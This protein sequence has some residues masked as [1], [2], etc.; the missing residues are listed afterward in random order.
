MM[1]IEVKYYAWLR[2]EFGDKEFLEVEN[3]AT[4]KEVVEKLI[5]K[6]ELLGSE[7][8]LISVNGKIT[9]LDTVLKEGDVV[10]IFPP[11]GGG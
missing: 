3:R 9:G 10:S 4:L 1:R 7:N 8:F 2:E 6:H 11:A 5:E